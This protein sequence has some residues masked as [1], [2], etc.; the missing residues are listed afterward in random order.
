MKNRKVTEDTLNR[1]W[2]GVRYEKSNPGEGEDTYYSVPSSL[3]IK[4][5]ATTGEEEGW[6]TSAASNSFLHGLHLR[7]LVDWT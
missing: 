1:K 7:Q 4:K 6:I 3:L 5:P 2:L